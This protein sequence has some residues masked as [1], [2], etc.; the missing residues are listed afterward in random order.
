MPRIYMIMVAAALSTAAARLWLRCNRKLTKRRGFKNCNWLVVSN[1]VFLWVSMSYMDIYI[2]DVI[3]QPLTNS[4]IFQ[5][6]RS[7]TNQVICAS[8]T[9]YFLPML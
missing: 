6:G 7:T 1:M 8:K 5:R 9:N 2:W 3:R 4:I